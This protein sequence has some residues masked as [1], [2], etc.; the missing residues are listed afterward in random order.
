MFVP[1]MESL[2]KIVDDNDINALDALLKPAGRI[3]N[4]T[5]QFKSALMLSAHNL[6][7]LLKIDTVNS[8][9]VMLNLE[10]GVSARQKPVALRLTAYFLSKIHQSPKK[11]VVRVNALDEGGLEEISFLN[12][13]KPDAIRV[14]KI[15]TRADVEQVLQVLDDSI[16][17][18]LSI[19]TKEAF[20]NL[21]T[22]QIE[23]RVK[24]VYL[25]IL[26]LLADLGLDQSIIIPENPI[27]HY[28]LAEFLIVAKSIGAYPVSF[29]YQDYQNMQEFQ[30]WLQLEKMMGY[31]AK[32]CVSPA[33]A[34]E[35]M[36]AF[37]L[38]DEELE[39][40]RYIIELFEKMQEQGVTGFSD[41][42]YGFIDEPIYK[43][44]LKTLKKK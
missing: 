8:D 38:K 29:V 44:A 35:V 32:G 36:K 7:H 18:H 10:D 25:G 39:R 1:Q 15:R 11:L 12:A 28:L 40:A 26:D 14:P 9:C 31:N 37:E 42:K 23:G 17:L 43:G 33:Q 13:Y 21:K 19:E 16:E 22:L 4:R 27:I 5:Q 20:T 2:K 30:R 24:V 3:Q 6:K 41:E 34:D